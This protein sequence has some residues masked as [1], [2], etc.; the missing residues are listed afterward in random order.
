MIWS[1]ACGAGLVVV[2]VVVGNGKVGPVLYKT[3][4]SRGNSLGTY[5]SDLY[6]TTG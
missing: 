6:N 2:V 1:V 3:K 4:R 5:L